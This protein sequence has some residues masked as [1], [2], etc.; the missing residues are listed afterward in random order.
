MGKENLRVAWVANRALQF[1]ASTI[2]LDTMSDV[3]G[4][5]I[6]RPLKVWEAHPALVKAMYPRGL[7]YL[8]VGIFEEARGDFEMMMKADKSFEPDATAAS[9]KP[10]QKLLHFITCFDKQDVE[11][12][13]RRQFKGLLTRCPG[14]LLILE[15]ITG[16]EHSTNEN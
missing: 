11:K 13:A 9:K 7:A 1:P 12:K 2:N 3:V 14:K 15:R 5:V 4:V 6:P 16:E 8:D 10:E